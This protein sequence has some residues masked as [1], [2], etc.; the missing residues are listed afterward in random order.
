MVQF[1]VLGILSGIVQMR[2]VFS[3]TELFSNFKPGISWLFMILNA[4]LNILMTGLIGRLFRL[5]LSISADLLSQPVEY[6]GCQRLSGRQRP[7]EYIFSSGMI[8]L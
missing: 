3:E 8:R 7:L 1:I 6:G 5:N 2:M 4:M